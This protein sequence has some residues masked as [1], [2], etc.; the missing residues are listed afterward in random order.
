MALSHS[1]SI[2]TD[3]LIMY[4][5]AANTRSYP[6]TGTAWTNLSSQGNSCTLTN[7]PAY[8]TETSPNISFD[9]T[10]DYA[11]AN[12]NTAVENL[13]ATTSF[14]F[15]FWAKFNATSGNRV[16]F[17]NGD[18]D[19]ELTSGYQ[20]RASPTGVLRILTNNA[21]LFDLFSVSYSG[22]GEFVGTWNNFVYT[23]TVSTGKVYRNGS[24]LS[25]NVPATTAF[26]ISSTDPLFI[27]MAP[28]NTRHTNMNLAVLK[29]YNKTLSDSEVLQNFNALRGRFGI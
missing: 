26:I 14:S 27:G 15:S 22:L 4:L 2:V 9:G 19:F 29:M 12:A 1:P 3:G 25:Q 5:D 11:V 6:G 21:V 23:N 7:G 8:N 10:N 28:F 17:G 13:M 20:V 18:P 24:L 16:V